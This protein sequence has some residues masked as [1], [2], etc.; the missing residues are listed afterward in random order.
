MKR[1]NS[2]GGLIVALV[3]YLLAVLTILR[4]NQMGEMKAGIFLAGV[5][6]VLGTFFW[7]N[8]TTRAEGKGKGS[9][10]MA[11]PKRSLEE[12]K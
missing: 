9:K 3:F 6:I 12:R 7:I 10:Q 11:T 4:F 1:K 2:I 5:E 8:E